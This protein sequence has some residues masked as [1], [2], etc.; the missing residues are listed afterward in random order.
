MTNA[1]LQGEEETTCCTNA[2]KAK[3]KAQAKTK[4][5]AKAK[6]KKKVPAAGQPCG[7]D[8]DTSSTHDTKVV[9][10]TANF[11]KMS[12]SYATALCKG[13]ALKSSPFAASLA[14]QLYFPMSTCRS[15]VSHADLQ[16]LHQYTYTAFTRHT[17]Q[18]TIT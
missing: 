9:S 8:L 15:C 11:C 2:V 17:Q 6:A 16:T 1:V 3:A 7:K 18:H 10:A 5:M 13:L 14:K 4:A 12:R